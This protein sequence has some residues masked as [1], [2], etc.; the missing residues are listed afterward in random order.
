MVLDL[1]HGKKVYDWLGVHKVV[2][3]GVRWSVCL[4]R[5]K[6][7]QA[8]AIAGIGLKQNDT[9][10]DL[11]CGAGVNLPYLFDKVGPQEKSWRW[12]TV[13][14]WRKFLRRHLNR[15]FAQSGDGQ[16]E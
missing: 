2:Y 14:V 5:E 8:R 10:L 9:V 15:G 13:C 6:R 7:L 3:R 4:G 1:S 12:T 11:A 16:E